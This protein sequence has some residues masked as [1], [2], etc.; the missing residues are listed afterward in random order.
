MNFDPLPHIRSMCV[1]IIITTCCHLSLRLLLPIC[2]LSAAQS[3]W[4]HSPV[5]RIVSHSSEN[6][7]PDAVTS[8]YFHQSAFDIP[9]TG[10][11]W[12]FFSVNTS[13]SHILPTDRL[14]HACGQRLASVVQSLQH[15]REEKF[16][17]VLTERFQNSSQS[18]GSDRCE[19]SS[20]TM[21]QALFHFS[22]VPEK[23]RL[24][25]FLTGILPC[26]IWWWILEPSVRFWFLSSCL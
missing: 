8:W 6:M 18:A 4:C 12:I 1:I 24:F 7:W 19:V 5:L 13:I 16:M 25:I 9:C 21:L 23:T 20:W 11:W 2:A 17:L 26:L 22:D 10:T 14:I 3:M 15:K